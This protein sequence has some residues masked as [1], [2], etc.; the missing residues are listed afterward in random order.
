[1]SIDI[2]PEA[3]DSPAVA[4]KLWFVPQGVGRCAGQEVSQGVY[5]LIG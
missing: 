5:F 2:Y 3:H 4:G 1:V